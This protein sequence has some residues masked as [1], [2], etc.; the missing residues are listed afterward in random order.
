MREWQDEKIER[1]QS[2]SRAGG[3]RTPCNPA[4]PSRPS[5]KGG[6]PNL[7]PQESREEALESKRGSELKMV[8]NSKLR[9]LAHFFPKYLKSKIARRVST[10]LILSL[11]I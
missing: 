10:T 5:P 7:S 11:I 4:K 9:K 8:S 2:K 1:D 3:C 6:T